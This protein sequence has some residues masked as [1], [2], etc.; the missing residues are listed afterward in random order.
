MP[1]DY[2]KQRRGV[3][4]MPPKPDGVI[5]AADRAAIAGVPIR[6]TF[7]LPSSMGYGIFGSG[8]FGS[9]IMSPCGRAY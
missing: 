2:E 1:T 6:V 9:S 4:G 7:S 8:I 5:S 3:A